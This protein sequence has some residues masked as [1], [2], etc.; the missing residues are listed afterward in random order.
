LWRGTAPPLLHTRDL[1]SLGNVL[2][3][4]GAVRLEVSSIGDY[5]YMYN[6]LTPPLISLARPSVPL[7]LNAGNAE[8]DKILY[9]AALFNRFGKWRTPYGFGARHPDDVFDGI[10]Y[11]DLLL[12]DLGLNSWRKGWGLVGEL[13]GGSYDQADYRGLVDEWKESQGRKEA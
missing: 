4:Q 12:Q 6:K 2:Q 13:F 10:P 1:V 11:F 3:L 9:D 5:A 8:W 7:H